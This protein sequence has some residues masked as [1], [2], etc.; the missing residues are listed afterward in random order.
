ANF[1]VYSMNWSPNQITFLVDGVGYYTYNP[2]DKNDSTW[3]FYEDQFILLNLAIEG[4]SGTTDSDFTQATMIVDYVKVYQEVVLG[5][6]NTFDLD[7]SLKLY[8][9]PATDKIHI[10]S[11]M[12]I[13]GLALYDVYGKLI[14]T[15]ENNTKSIDVS[16]LNSG[17]YFLEV[18]SSTQKAVKKVMV[19]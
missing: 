18:S 10:S 7:A 9:N 6:N 1:H 13:S 2:S 17:V 12:P 16:R 5:A 15:K 19:K 3:P 14:F 4:I 11:K 8:P